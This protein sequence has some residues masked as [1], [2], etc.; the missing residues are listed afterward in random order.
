MFLLFPLIS[1]SESYGLLVSS[2]ENTL[3]ILL[4]HLYWW[5]PFLSPRESSVP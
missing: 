1:H 5:I 3:Q 4:C 2:Q